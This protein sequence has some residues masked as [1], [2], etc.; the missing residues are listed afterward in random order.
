MTVRDGRPS[1]GGR[2]RALERRCAE[3]LRPGC[4]GCKDGFGMRVVLVPLGEEQPPFNEHC[5]ECGRAFGE[6]EGLLM[7]LTEEGATGVHAP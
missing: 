4:P 6:S 7:V 3:A 2:L 1:V 5:R